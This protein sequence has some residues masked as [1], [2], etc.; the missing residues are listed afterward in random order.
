[1]WIRC[2]EFSIGKRNLPKGAVKM[3]KAWINMAPSAF[4]MDFKK[5]R[6]FG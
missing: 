4:R 2:G 1:M 3:D 6:Y 5:V